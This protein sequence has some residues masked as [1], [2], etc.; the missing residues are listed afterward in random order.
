MIDKVVLLSIPIE[1]LK[2]IIGHA[3]QEKLQEFSSTHLNKKPPEKEFLTRQ[4]V[5]QMLQ[6]NSVTLWRYAREGRLKQHR[7]GRKVFFFAEEVR[8][9]LLNT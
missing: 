7:V 4:E 8:E 5:C 3:V 2:E 9:A 6:I 1:E